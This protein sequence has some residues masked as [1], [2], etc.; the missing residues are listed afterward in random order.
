MDA[1]TGIGEWSVVE[2]APTNGNEGEGEGEGK[3]ES[4][5]EEGKAYVDEDEE[6]GD[7]VR[8]FKVV[9][10]CL[11]VDDEIGDAAD[12][13]GAVFRKRKVGGKGKEGRNVRRRSGD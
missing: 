11:P 8:G 13:V 6:V 9:E 1:G 2:S 5:K 10:K 7:N 4:D 3:G 12:A